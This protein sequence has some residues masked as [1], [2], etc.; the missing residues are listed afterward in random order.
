[1]DHCR[2]RYGDVFTVDLLARAITGPGATPQEGSWVF[3]ADPQDV[4]RVF[5]ADPGRVLTGA[6][7]RFLE[8]LVGSRSILVLD[9]PAH[10]T[11]RRLMLPPLH[12]D[13]VRRYSEVMS[14]VA[15][16]EVARWPRG[17][18]FPL[19][20]RMQAIT[21]EVIARAVFGVS[22]PR[23]LGHLQRLLRDML[24]RM[25]SRRWLIAHSLRAS[26]AGPQRAGGQ[27]TRSAQV[28]LGPIEQEL[29]A[30]IRSRRSAPDLEGRDDILSMLVQSRYDDGSQMTDDELR[31]ELV[32]LLIAGHESTA[33]ALAWAFERLLRT[34]DALERLRDEAQ[35]EQD[36]YADAVVK[37]TL[38][39]RPVLPFVLRKLAAPMELGGYDLP[40]GTWVAPCAWLIHRRE[41][42]YP[43]PDRFRPER[44]LE[45][46]AGT[47]TWLPFGGGSRRCLGAS[48]AQLEIKEVLR[49]VL[50]RVEL[51]AAQPR[52][53]RIASRFI[54]LAP[55][56]GARVVVRRSVTARRMA[57]SAPAESVPA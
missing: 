50:A 14:D 43:E 57:A 42:V 34:S 13:R 28:L 36:E 26:V 31:D 23:R 56:A 1:L 11:Q 12:G 24:N 16:A 46:P 54:T 32:T 41:D 30:E 5:T 51:R 17:D 35:S 9:E 47:Y 37:E 52:S 22:E 18:S 33:T 7:N 4:K 2:E 6:T 53:E 44:F 45:R 8:G 40:A 38:R 10:M 27:R 20:P 48:F 25:T 21:V 29:Y 55:S 49:A 15:A 39:L 3:L 19:W